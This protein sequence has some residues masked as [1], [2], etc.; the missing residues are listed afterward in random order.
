[1]PFPSEI[2]AFNI[3]EKPVGRKIPANFAQ[4]FIRK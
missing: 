1:M 3:K 2:N 4:L